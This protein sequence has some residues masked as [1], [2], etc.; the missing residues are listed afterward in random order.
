MARLARIRRILMRS[1]AFL[2]LLA[3]A[4]A[5]VVAPAMA[6]VGSSMQTYF[7]DAGSAANVTGPTA[8][9]GQN[10][11]Y[12]SAGNVWMRFP[13]KN[14]QPFNLQLPHARARTTAPMSPKPAAPASGSASCSG[15]KSGLRYSRS[16]CS[17]TPFLPRPIR[18]GPGGSC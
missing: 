2:G 4:E 8:F 14:I 18:P 1:G 17:T 15:V 11:G 10:A 5:T 13:Q 9:Y 6:D 16:G 7:N 12:Y 3:C